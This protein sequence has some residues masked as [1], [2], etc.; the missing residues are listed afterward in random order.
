MPRRPK[1]GGVREYPAMVEEYLT[2][3]LSRRM[4]LPL[5]ER[6]AP[7]CGLLQGELNLLFEHRDG[8]AWR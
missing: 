4:R 7:D 5:P 8:A 1:R 2:D 6:G 3:T